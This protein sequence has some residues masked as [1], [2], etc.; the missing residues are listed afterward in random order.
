M[1]TSLVLALPDFTQRMFCMQTNVMVYG[2]RRCY[3]STHSLIRKSMKYL[4]SPAKP[5]GPTRNHTPTN[6]CLPFIH[7]SKSLNYITT[8]VL[9][10]KQQQAQYVSFTIMRSSE[11]WII[12]AEHWAIKLCIQTA[13]CNKSFQ[14]LIFVLTQLHCGE[15][16]SIPLSAKFGCPVAR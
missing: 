9:S 10:S 16:S 14:S 3:S 11:K 12:L 1:K 13:G 15:W 5:Q 4:K 8:Q 2:W 7:E 6:Q